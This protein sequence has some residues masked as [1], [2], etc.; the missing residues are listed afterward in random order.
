VVNGGMQVTNALAA[1]A[2]IDLTTAYNAAAAQTP[3]A[4]SVAFIGAGETLTP[5][6][7]NATT[8]LDVS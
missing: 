5:G 3:T 2:Q 7:Y 4:P 6:V 8:A 1:Q